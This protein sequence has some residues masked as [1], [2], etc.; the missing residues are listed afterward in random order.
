MPTTETHLDGRQP[1]P[2]A[3]TGGPPPSPRTEPAWVRWALP[4]L[5]AGALLAVWEAAPR[6]GWVSPTLIPPASETLVEAVVV[7]GDPEFHSDALA[8]GG[9]W[10]MGVALAV[11]IGI[12][13]GLVMGRNRVVF[14]LIDPILTLSYPV[15]RAV[16]I[17]VFVFWWGAGN[18]ARVVTIVLGCLIPIV[19]SAY[20]GAAGVQPALVWSARSL[21]SSRLGVLARVV[22]P[23]ALPQ[24]LSGLRV[25][26]TIS[27]FVLLASELLVRQSGVGAYLFTHYDAGQNVTVW[28]CVVLLALAG[29]AI[30]ALYVLG[31]RRGA[32]WLEGEV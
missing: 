17:L 27:L 7:L 15:P 16:L 1:G 3:T 13:M 12:P 29:Y 11:L 9:R 18:L 22:F 19:I 2:A 4:L 28:A 31:V 5:T 26:L 10:A 30:D 25:A 6:V 20:H 21:G 14:H 8:S 23:A 24:I 32:R